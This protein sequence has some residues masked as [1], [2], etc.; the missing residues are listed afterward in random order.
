MDFQLSIKESL[1]VTHCELCLEL[2][3]CF[4]NDTDY[5]EDRGSAECEVCDQ[6]E[7]V[8]CK[9]SAC[10]DSRNADDV[11]SDNRCYCRE[12]RDEA[13]ED[14]TDHGNS[15][16][17][18]FD[19][20]SSGLTGTDAGNGS[21]I[22]SYVVRYFNRIE[23]D[24]N[25]EVRERD[26]K[27]NAEEHIDPRLGIKI[28]G[29]GCEPFYIGEECCD[30][31]GKSCNGACKDDGHN[32][33]HIDLEGK[34]CSLS[35]VHLSSD[36]TLSVL[37]RDSSLGVCY[38][39]DETDDSDYQSDRN[40]CKDKAY[41]VE[42]AE[43][44]CGEYETPNACCELGNSGNDVYKEY[45]RDTVAH[46]VFVDLLSEPHNDTCTC[47]IA[48]DDYRKLYIVHSAFGSV[49]GERAVEEH[50]CV[51]VRGYDRKCHSYPTGDHLDL[52]LTCFAVLGHS[53]ERRDRDREKLDNDGC[54]DV[55]RNTECKQC[56]LAERT[57]RKKV[58]ILENGARCQGKC[59]GINERNGDA[60][61]ETVNNNDKQ[62]EE[63]LVFKLCY[64]PSV[65]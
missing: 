9:V 11:F 41:P 65:F 22:V 32:T 57:T 14:R 3:E 62:C 36:N 16:E 60:C 35:A 5:D 27:N 8:F 61:T 51:T 12:A 30:G 42:A 52:L 24:H 45:H 43:A 26:D 46:T 19:V 2:V 58:H 33:G 21:A 6:S 28:V 34:V 15:V 13:E 7:S 20:V 25:V 18:L 39:N 50:L 23:G 4:E 64:L 38:T 31:C 44:A 1:V 37:D 49:E 40:D 54:S 47:A 56:C 17:Y 53:L 29:N 10:T 59:V 48:C 55:R 63:E